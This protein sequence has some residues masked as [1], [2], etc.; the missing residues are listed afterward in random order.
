VRFSFI[1]RPCLL[2]TPRDLKKKLWKRA[3]LSIGAHWGTWRRVHLLGTFRDSKR[4]LDKC[5]I[6]LYGRSVSGTWRED[7][8]TGN[9]ES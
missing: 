3:S 1:R 7:S 4:V 2:E 6:S 8:F 9:S 5:S